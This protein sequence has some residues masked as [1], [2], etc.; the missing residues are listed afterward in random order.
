MATSPDPIAHRKLALSKQLYQHAVNQAARHAVGSR[1]L[2][3]IAFDLATETLL[4]TVVTSLAPDKTPAD[5]FSGLL[6]QVESVLAGAGL[7]ALPDK[8]NIL[9][10]HG[11]RNDAQHK[12]RYP[13]V[14]DVNDARTYTRDFLDKLAVTVW[15]L[16][17]DAITLVDLVQNDTVRTYLRAAET[18]FAASDY[19][20][21]AQHAAIA[22][23]WT[24]ERVQQ[25]FVGRLPGFIGG[26]EVTSSTGRRSDFD[27]RAVLRSIELTQETVLWL[28]LGLDVADV[29]RFWRL[30]GHVYFTMDGQGHCEGTKADLSV[31]EAEFVMA[32]AIDLA[33]QVESRVGDIEK[34]FGR[35]DWY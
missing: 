27:A 9:H 24:L 23:H 6:Q 19:V 17:F 5:G 8:A 18:A 25:P 7:G 32:L 3:I 10:V 2:A 22:T 26:I 13:S 20:Q 4:R 33:Y 12:A 29:V 16:Q 31:A 30:A 14:S 15:G 1:V 21:A 11:F 34:P 35:E 28:A